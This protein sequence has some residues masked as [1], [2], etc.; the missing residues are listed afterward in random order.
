MPNIEDKCITYKDASTC[1]IMHH[2]HFC[3][4]GNTYA[5][6]YCDIYHIDENGEAQLLSNPDFYSY[7]NSNM[8]TINKPMKLGSHSNKILKNMYY[9]ANDIS[10]CAP[11][12]SDGS[13]SF[14]ATKNYICIWYDISVTN[15]MKLGFVDFGN[16]SVPGLSKDQAAFML[17][18]T[19][20]NTTNQANINHNINYV[21]VN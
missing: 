10:Q 11:S 18:I 19:L 9:T 7:I 12:T 8:I 2:I 1:G 14:S 3:I 13:D 5:Q 20:V 17:T 6:H 15:Q 4:Y 21:Y 16:W